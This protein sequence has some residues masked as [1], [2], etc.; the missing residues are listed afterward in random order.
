MPRL[1]LDPTS[2][3]IGTVIGTFH[4]PSSSSLKP[5]P[6][7]PTGDG[8]GACEASRRPLPEPREIW[9]RQSGASRAPRGG[10]HRR[11]PEKTLLHQVVRDRLEPFLALARERSARGHGLPAFVER[12]LR[13]Y[14][15]CCQGNQFP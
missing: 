11:E 6:A 3:V 12:E 5:L 14:L 2:P 8:H 1:V 4:R 9:E 7:E 15:D 10:Y 13:A